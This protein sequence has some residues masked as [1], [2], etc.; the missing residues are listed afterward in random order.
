MLLF[1]Q[2]LRRFPQF[3]SHIMTVS[4]C[5][6]ELNA[7]SYCAASLKY[8]APD[9]YPDTESTSPSSLN[10][11]AKQGTAST[12]FNDFGMSRPRIEPRTS[13]SLEQTLYLLSYRGQ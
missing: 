2:V 6:R 4:C 12:I 11:S 13:R 5:D 7:H 8:H 9:N 10:L 3:F 1:V